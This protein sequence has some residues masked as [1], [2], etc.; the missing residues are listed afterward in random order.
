[1]RKS[2]AYVS[3]LMALVTGLALGVGRPG[4]LDDLLT[5]D[6][7]AGWSHAVPAQS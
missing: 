1:M 6:G 5:F 7:R 4:C 3:L 2:D